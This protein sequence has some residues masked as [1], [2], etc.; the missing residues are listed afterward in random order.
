VTQEK[1][2]STLTRHD[3]FCLEMPWPKSTNAACFDDGVLLF[4]IGAR[5]DSNSRIEPSLKQR[6]ES[7]QLL[8]RSQSR[9]RPLAPL[10]HRPR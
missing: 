2:S 5:C 4:M 6:S 1:K 7:Y 8:P 10:R 9:E 3:D